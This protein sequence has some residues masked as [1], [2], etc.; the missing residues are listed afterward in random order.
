MSGLAAVAGVDPDHLR[1]HHTL[2]PFKSTVFCRT[3]RPPG[4]RLI[5]SW[6]DEL[7]KSTL[8]FCADCVAADLDTYG[9]SYWRREHQ[10][11]GL[12]WCRKHRRG[13][14]E[15]SRDYSYLRPPSTLIDDS[16]EFDFE[17]VRT[18]WSDEYIARY[19]GVLGA[20]LDFGETTAAPVVRD[21]L[22]EAARPAGYQLHPNRGQKL[23]DTEVLSQQAYAKLPTK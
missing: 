13:L 12:Y 10:L 16:E 18:L 5:S 23:L 4:E 2:G 15:T 14:R 7:T 22:R 17:W 19:L 1:R 8:R 9:R 3:R 20:L 6:G 11:P 21:A